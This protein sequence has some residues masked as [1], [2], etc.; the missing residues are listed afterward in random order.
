M[1]PTNQSFSSLYSKSGSKRR[2]IPNRTTD[3][4]WSRDSQRER[5]STSQPNDTRNERVTT[6]HQRTR[7]CRQRVRLARARRAHAGGIRLH[8]PRVL[9]RTVVGIT[10]MMGCARAPVS[11]LLVACFLNFCERRCTT[12]L[13]M[14][15][16]LGRVKAT[17]LDEE[18]I[19]QSAEG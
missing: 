4:S 6:G 17:P 12:A 9:R 8:C 7:V 13:L 1:T 10:W 5:N 15:L 19:N 18:E 3:R 2:R 14:E 11:T 16:A